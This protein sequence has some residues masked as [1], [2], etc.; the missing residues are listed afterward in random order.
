MVYKKLLF[1]VVCL[2]LCANFACIF[3][4]IFETEDSYLPTIP[5]PV[6]DGWKEW[7]WAKNVNLIYD[8]LQ[9]GDKKY[10]DQYFAESVKF[11]GAEFALSTREAAELMKNTHYPEYPYDPEGARVR[12]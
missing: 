6:P 3:D 8:V 12:N 10:A 4:S 5:H 11:H 2:F 7:V 9:R 1:I